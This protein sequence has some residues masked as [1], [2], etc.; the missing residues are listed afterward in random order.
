MSTELHILAETTCH[1]Q[2]SAILQ[3]TRRETIIQIMKEGSSN[4]QNSRPVC[5]KTILKCLKP[6]STRSVVVVR[7]ILTF[8][9][10]Y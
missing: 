7:E 5:E 1:R 10:T 3:T 2:N 8:K 9:G 6:I 4:A